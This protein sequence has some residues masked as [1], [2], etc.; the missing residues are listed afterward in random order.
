MD[1]LDKKMKFAQPANRELFEQAKAKKEEAKKLDD[2]KKKDFFKRMAKDEDMQKEY[3]EELIPKVDLNIYAQSFVSDFFN[4]GTVSLGDPLWYEMEFE[5]DPHAKVNYLSQHGGTPSETMVTDGDLVRIHPYFIQTPEVHMNKR[6]LKQGDISNEQKMRDKLAR[7]M[8]KRMTKDMWSLLDANLVGSGSTLEEDMQIILDEDYKNFPETN[9]IDANSEGGLTLDI[10]K[11]IADH[12][13]RLNLQV[14]NIYVPANRVKDIYDW[15]SIDSGT[16]SKVPTSI[17]EEVVRTGLVSNLFGYNVNLVPVHTLDGTE[18]NE[19]N[20]IELF[21]STSSPA[22]E[23][24]NVRELDDVYRE[25]DAD[26][27]Y[28]TETKGLAMFSAPYQKMNMLRVVFDSY[29][30]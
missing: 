4:V 19:D 1:N 28:F 12:F 14:N 21:V 10:F 23:V 30:G 29:S 8:N 22:G 7:G 9:N 15:I 5:V 24:R 20:E 2:E 25:E 18:G 17:H 6:S 11:T 26:R 16:G 13:N 3:A 27:I